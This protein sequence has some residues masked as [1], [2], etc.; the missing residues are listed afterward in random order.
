[1]IPV[2]KRHI[3]LIRYNYI[4]HAAVPEIGHGNRPAVKS[5]I[6]TNLAGYVFK[7][8]IAVIEPYLVLLVSRLTLSLHIGPVGGIA[9]DIAVPAGYFGIIIPIGGSLFSGNKTIGGIQ[10]H[11]AVIVEISELSAIAPARILDPR[12]LSQVHEEWRPARPRVLW[13]PVVIALDQHT[14][15][16]NIGSINA[17]RPIVIDI[18]ER[19]THPALGDIAYP[20]LFAAF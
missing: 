15:F 19:Y 12:Q 18:T 11:K 5:N 20:G 3:V 9:D 2:N 1:M 14:R 16:G 13:L 17:Q 6:G 8:T 10:V 7:K 4:Q